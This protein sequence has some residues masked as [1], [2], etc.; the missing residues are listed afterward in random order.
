[1]ATLRV[2]RMV[3]VLAERLAKYLVVSLDY[4]MAEGLVGWKAPTMGALLAGL[5][6][7]MSGLKEVAMIELQSVALK[8]V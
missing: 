5:M 3:D 6:A 1:M 2:D 4:W 8:V 7:E